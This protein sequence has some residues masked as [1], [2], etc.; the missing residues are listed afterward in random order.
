MTKSKSFV[1]ISSG[2]LPLINTERLTL[3]QMVLE[4]C[5]QVYAL[6]S[7]KETSQL[8]GR[9]KAVSIEDATAFIN[10]IQVGIEENKWLFWAIGEA[11]SNLFMGSICLWN[12]SKDRKTA[13][14][15][16]E[17]LSEFR[18]KG[19]MQ[20]AITAI[21]IFG[22]ET[23]HL[24]CIEAV[25]HEKNEKSIRLLKHFNFQPSGEF[26]EENELTGEASRMLVFRNEK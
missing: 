4:D 5:P 26:E 19:F 10:K 8:L 23:L 20:E 7:D 18:G 1:G 15:G 21:V 11:K 14:I 2:Q 16:Y 6:R 24:D 9:K 3:R 25:V 13:E 17:L 22:F 12:F